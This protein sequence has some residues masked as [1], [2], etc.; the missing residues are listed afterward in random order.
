MK[1]L[2]DTATHRI[3][4]PDDAIVGGPSRIVSPDD[5]LDRLGSVALDK[6]VASNAV[7]ARAFV[8]RLQISEQIFLD[9]P[10]FSAALDRLVPGVITAQERDNARA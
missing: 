2:L 10:A 7:A 4:V 3:E 8:L 9:A 6:I 5:F 1:K